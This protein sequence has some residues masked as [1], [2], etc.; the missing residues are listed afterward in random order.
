MV[1]IEIFTYTSQ[2]DEIERNKQK[3]ETKIM[4]FTPI[5]YL[6]LKMKP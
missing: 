5:S 6:S 1:V 2:K 4:K 3:Q